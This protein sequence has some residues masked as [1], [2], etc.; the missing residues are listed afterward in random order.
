MDSGSRIGIFLTR[1]AIPLVY[2]N[3]TNFQDAHRRQK[4]LTFSIGPGWPWHAAKLRLT[5]VFFPLGSVAVVRVGSG[6]PARTS[7]RQRL[8]VERD[9]GGSSGAAV[10]AARR[11]GYPCSEQMIRKM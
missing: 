7:Y 9:L 11:A 4:G 6:G 2:K 10:D 3:S 1:P 5:R 8:F